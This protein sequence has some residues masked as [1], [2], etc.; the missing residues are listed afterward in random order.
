MT[1]RGVYAQTPEYALLSISQKIP[2]ENVGPRF[3]VTA[4]IRHGFPHVWPGFDCRLWSVSRVSENK[5]FPTPLDR[6]A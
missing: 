4:A 1:L 5:C 3:S 6:L 2:P